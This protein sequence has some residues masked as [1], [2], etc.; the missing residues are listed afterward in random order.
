MEKSINEM[1]SAELAAVITA[2][3][4]AD[5]Q[6]LRAKREAERQAEYAIKRARHLEV[7]RKFAA[8]IVE[9]LNAAAPEAYAKDPNF[10]L[11]AVETSTS[12]E[13]I[14]VKFAS[15]D[16]KYRYNPIDVRSE[17]VKIGY[18]GEGMSTY[19]ANSKGV[20]NTK[21]LA[22]KFWSLVEGRAQ[23]DAE[24]AKRYENQNKSSDL[25]KQVREDV[26]LSDFG[27]ISIQSTSHDAGKVTVKIERSRTLNPAQATRLAK[28]LKAAFELS[29]TLVKQESEK[30]S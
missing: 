1:T 14:V 27:D 8:P 7:C 22:E 17:T 20:V 29:D 18:I 15:I 2:R 12:Y 3:E 4:E 23:R 28:M 30:Q 19:R 11:I 13:P 5:R 6:A 25:A 24:Q 16:G 10:K 21:K 26:G 9:A